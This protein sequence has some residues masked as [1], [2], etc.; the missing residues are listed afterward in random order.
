MILLLD[1]GNSRCKW[2]TADPAFR[3]GGALDYD[4]F[5]EQ[6]EDR[7]ARIGRPARALAVSVAGEARTAPLADW[8]RARFGVA[9]ETVRAVND[10]LGVV[11]GY[12]APERL[13]ADR[14]AA[15]LG[16]RART[17]GAACVIDCGTAIT[18]DAL[19]RAGVFRGGVILPG[20]GLQRAAVQRGTQGVRAA[21]GEAKDC[22]ARSTDDAVNSGVLFG[23]AGAIERIVEEQAR[24]LGTPVTRLI[25][26][27]DAPRLR[28]LLRMDTTPV[29]DL[30]LEGVARIAGVAVP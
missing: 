20:V 19:D 15:L 13:G 24:V 9:L 11:N 5:V 29:P 2:A 25:T 27:G 28:P 4:D 3:P 22:L 7:L 10:Q 21:P 30:V 1:L 14:W 18:V 17:A 6:L 8:L 16:A 12:D 23:I 26:G